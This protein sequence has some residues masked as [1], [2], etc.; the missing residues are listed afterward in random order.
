MKRVTE[1]IILILISFSFFQSCTETTTSPQETEEDDI[2]SGGSATIFITGSQAYSQ[3]VPNLSAENLEKHLAGDLQFEQSFVKAPAQVNPG[4]GPLF[5]NNSCINCHIADGRGQPPQPGQQLETML[6]RISIPGTGIN[7]SPNPVPGFGTQLQDK[8]IIGFEPEGSVQI[9]YNEIAGEYPDGTEYSLRKPNYSVT[10]RVPG[11]I[12][13]SPRV[14]PFVFGLGLLESIPEQSIIENADENDINQDGVSGKPNYVWNHS[15]NNFEL[16]RFGWKANTPTL[17]QQS[18]AAYNNDIGITST[19]FPLEN[20]HENTQCD[21]ASDDPEITQEILKKVE[22]YVQ[23]LGVPARRNYKDPVVKQGKLLFKEI[24]CINC[25][26]TEFTT[27]INTKIPELS[28]QKIHPYTDLLLHDMGEELSDDRPD[29]NAAGR[30]WR[31]PPLWG[32]GLVEIVNGH[33]SFMHD[34]RARNLEEAILWHF[35]EGEKSRDKFINLSK[36]ERDALI[37]YL[38]SL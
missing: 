5:N 31:T 6:I 22:F 14:A 4:L 20:C 29:Y 13:V 25:H 15:N 35:G 28:N 37:E 11:G 34:G 19:L 36:D 9:T 2:L 12:L 7:N 27:G 21:T 24:G 38:K 30:E 1:Y 16:G 8:S 26:V 18:A 33:T 23:T 32:I 17:Y 3:P 10:G